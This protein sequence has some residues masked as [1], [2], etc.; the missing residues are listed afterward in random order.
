MSKK[1]RQHAPAWYQKAIGAR[2]IVL[3]PIVSR[4]QILGLIYADSDTPQVLK[5]SA[6][7]LGLLK[8]LRNRA[9]LALRQMGS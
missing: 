9:V 1:P 4:K 8:T 7:E 2:G 6:G 5:F 3:L